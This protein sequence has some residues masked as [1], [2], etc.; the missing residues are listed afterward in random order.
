MPGSGRVSCSFP[1]SGNA[2]VLRAGRFAA[3]QTYSLDPETLVQTPLSK[4]FD[5]INGRLTVGDPQTDQINRLGGDLAALDDGNFL[6]VV[7]DRSKLHDFADP[8]VV[9]AIFR[10]D[11]SVVRDS[12]WIAPGPIWS[13]VAAFKGGFCVR[14]SGM[15]MFFDNVGDFLGQTDQADPG[16]VDAFGMPVLFD[17]GRG[18]G[19]RIAG[20]INSPYIYLAGRNGSDVHL[21]VWDARDGTYLAQINVNELTEAEGGR[22][23]ATFRPTMDRVNLAVDALN[24]V[25][26]A[27]DGT[28]AG[29]AEHQT[30]VRVLRFDAEEGEFDYLT[31]TFFPF[32]NTSDG[33]PTIN[34][35][36]RT[37]RPSLAM[38]TRQICVAA[39]G[40]INS[41]NEPWQGADTPLETNFYTVFSHPE[42]M[43]DPTPPITLDV[44]FR[45]GDVNADG[46]LDIADA[47]F[48]LGH[49][50]AGGAV[51]V[52]QD[53][54]DANDD[55]KLDIADA[56][57]ILGHLFGGA[58]SLP[59]PFEDC[60]VDPTDDDL[61]CLSFP[62]CE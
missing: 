33:A 56:I 60:G 57:T 35:G 1:V 49:L 61:D 22:D 55:G 45:R 37:M 3:V 28:L 13:N 15:L 41:A 32:V 38:T 25:A 52:C 8:A 44:T 23:E 30:F 50:F 14:V 17:R 9:A 2:R 51:P 48:L 43:A 34:D 47:I 40:E 54:A 27:Y 21:A 11:G 19:V 5:A 46:K 16:L 31:P 24:R 4:A 59:P 26:V 29:V 20:H 12:F 36:I 58:P 10:P 62:P 42:P 7:E 39:R 18:D 53:S 6:V